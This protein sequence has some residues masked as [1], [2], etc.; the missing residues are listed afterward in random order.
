MV[1]RW[2][3]CV[4]AFL[5]ATT[6]L[7]CWDG[8]NHGVQAQAAAS[9]NGTTMPP[10]T[11]IVDASLATWTIAS[12]KRILRNGAHV[13]LGYG[14]NIIWLNNTVYVFGTDN[15]WWAWNGYW[16]FIGQPPSG[17]ATVSPS[18]AATPPGT[19][20]VDSSLATWTIASDKRILRNG[21]HVALGYGTSILWLNDTVYVHG[22][23]NNW[24]SW[25][26]Q[27]VFIGQ[28]PSGGAAVS[29][30]GAATPP[31]A[32][33]VDSALATWTIASDKRILRNGVHVAL[34]Y[35]SS[36]LWLNDTIYVYGTN[37]YWYA[38]N[39]SWVF[40]GGSPLGGASGD[41][42]VS[43][44]DNIQS[45]INS[46]PDGAVIVLRAG[47][48]YGQTLT[49]KSGQTIVGDN[50]AILSGARVLTSSYRSGSAWVFPNQSQQSPF[51]GNCQAPSPRCGNSEE[52]FINDVRLK[53]VA[54][55]A[56]GGPGRWFFDYDS[57]LI[58]LWDDP[59][60]RR[61]ETS[62]SPYAFTGYATNVTIRNLVIEK[63]ANP[64]Q[65]GAIRGG[66]PG[67]LIESNTVRYNHGI[68]IEM[69]PGRRVLNNN[70]SGNGQLGIAGSGSNAVVDGNEVGYN[71][72]SGFNAYWEA[73][74][75]K[76]SHSS[77]LAARN[78]FVHHNDGTG[79]H[80]D[81]ENID[82]LIEYN[83][84]ED[85]TLSGI[86]HEVSYR[87]II[88]Y[89]SSSRN[90]SAKPDPWWV[91]GAG[92]LVSGASDVEVYG[93]V[94]VDNFQGITGL[95]NH[96][97]GSGALGEYI[98]KNL[99]VHDNEIRQTNTVDA[100]SGRTGIAEYDPSYIDVFTGLNNR[101]VNNKYYL[102]PRAQTFFWM[103]RD[104]TEHD[105]RAYNQDVGG[106]FLR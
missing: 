50:G 104:L 36:I 90:G 72:A 4:Q 92:I 32:S 34:G 13:P 57:D 46:A 9:P 21:V 100:G 58:Y 44:G 99:Y 66:G 14:T 25:N 65:T 1:N 41:Y 88:R 87:A 76:F 78:N 86:F 54:R 80:T 55:L 19:S 61:V 98:L 43:P 48:Y 59:G 69:G 17:G 10:A 60:G 3:H 73:G 49:P 103:H 96:Y 94:L 51:Y 53:H 16:V 37:S 33:V 62:V 8:S 20:I 22:T 85:N 12:D 93:N 23:D 15:N 81:G 26:G 52:L 29:P 63:Y 105:W 28:A 2:K 79:L 42:T 38:W 83:R 89:N 106:V 30:S 97:R 45:V 75:M 5:I 95:N 7:I 74:G 27:W 18:G 35:G 77:T 56:D 67:W 102:S 39:G 84:V 40:I 24:Y 31:A 11:S 70:A 91:D 68:G 47:V 6:A 101:F 82:M 64:A 71:N